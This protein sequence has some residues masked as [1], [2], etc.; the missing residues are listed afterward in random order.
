[1]G[2]TVRF[3]QFDLHYAGRLTIGR[4]QPLLRSRRQAVPVSQFLLAPGGAL[5][6]ADALVHT[7]QLTVSL[8][9]G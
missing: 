5:S 1:M 6:V 3:P 8:P 7:H 2:A 4:G 9:I